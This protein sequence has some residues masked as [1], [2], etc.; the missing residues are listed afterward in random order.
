M[1]NSVAQVVFDLPVEGPFDYDVPQA[2]RSSIQVGHRVLA[3]FHVKTLIGYVVTLKE[4][5]DFPQLKSI[6]S[7]LDRHPVVSGMMLENAKDFAREYY[8]SLGEAIATFLPSSFKKRRGEIVFSPGSASAGDGTANISAIRDLSLQKFWPKISEAMGSALARGLQVMV[9]VPENDRIS[10]IADEIRTRFSQ[11]LAI[12]DKE[13]S[14]KDQ[15]ERW[16]MIK[17]G[18]LSL[19]VGSRSAVFAPAERLGLIVMLEEDHFSYKQDQTPFYHARQVALL[20]AQRER[21]DLIF[22]S[23]FVSVQLKYFL[24]QR[25]IPIA[26]VE[27][28]SRTLVK[29]LVDLSNYKYRKNQAISIPLQCA[30]EKTLAQKGKVLLVMNKKGFGSFGSCAKCQHVLKCPRCDV[31]LTFLYQEQKVVCR[32]CQYTSDRPAAC[33]QCQGAYVNFS[34]MGI[35]KLESEASRLFPTAKVQCYSGDTAQPPDRCDIVVATQVFTR[36]HG[37]SF[38]LSC[39]M[40]VDSELNR[41]D[42]QAAEKTFALLT[43]LE[44]M[45]HNVVYLQARLKDNYC[46]K[47]FLKNNTKTFYKHELALRRE[48][49]FPPFVHLA[50][51]V[52][53]SV[54]SQAALQQS[55]RLYEELV[56][57][58]G[59]KFSFAEPQVLSLARL[60]DKY[61]FAIVAKGRSR[62]ELLQLIRRTLSKAKK[63]S[64]TT[65][66]VNLEP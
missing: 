53:R 24:D 21:F 9:V 39:V 31:P 27:Q 11:S 55:Q 42:F 30:I 49:Q 5:S 4:Q 7:V 20:R 8:C 57:K 41:L 58:N 14:D 13:A 64:Q 46:L 15:V 6:V 26:D 3:P 43:D 1:K 10:A 25:K 17:E 32:H 36:L 44:A 61:R 51:I 2:F 63:M 23:R 56:K 33:P 45:T 19:I 60:R 18:K 62:A 12:F 47:A 28:P 52:T 50:E 48:L 54:S 66:V 16:T 22:V 34:G 65:T 37:M 38:Q 35:E 40:D 59:K 29:Q